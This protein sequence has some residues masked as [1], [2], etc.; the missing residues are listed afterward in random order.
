MQKKYTKEDFLKKLKKAVGNKYKITGKYIDLN[1][2]VEFTHKKCNTTFMA[3]PNNFIYKH[4][5]C[6]ICRDNAH[7][8]SPEQFKKEFDE[9][10]Q[11]EYLLKT[12]YHR[13]H[14]KIKVVHT[15]CNNTYTVT[16]HDFLSGARCPYCYGNKRK[17]TKEFQNEVKKL[18]NNEYELLSEYHN[19]RTKV[20]IKHIKCERLYKV[21]PHDFLTGGTRCPYCNQ[22]HGEKLIENFLIDNHI[23]YETQKIFKD[24]TTGKTN[25]YLKYDFYLKDFNLLIEYDGIQ[26]FKP[27]KWFGGAKGFK[28][29][30][31]RDSIK[32]K[33]AIDNNITLIR[34]PYTLKE[35]S[36]ISEVKNLISYCKAEKSTPKSRFMI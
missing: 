26:H 11:G 3:T 18:T 33:Y 32:N 27:I 2:K 22:S 24:C 20:I 14:E 5:R 29:Q 36:V 23:N 30:Q 19:N 34:L 16:P 8:K 17:T 6:P 35:S 12:A 7:A 4:C 13:S 25:S 21:S 1:T 9:L 31:H 28:E 15:V 10:S